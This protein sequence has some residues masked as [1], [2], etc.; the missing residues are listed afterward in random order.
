MAARLP[1]N[2]TQACFAHLTGK[3]A[4]Q[5]GDGDKGVVSAQ[6]GE[7][8]GGCRGQGAVTPATENM[9]STICFPLLRHK[10]P[11]TWSLKTPL[12]SHRFLGPKFVHGSTRFSAQGLTKWKARCQPRLG[13]YQRLGDLSQDHLSVGRIHFPAAVEPSLLASSRSTEE[14]PLCQISDHQ[15]FRLP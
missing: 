14:S 4:G 11:Q 5:Q 8:C 13:S 9:S 7:G 3:V 6:P 12:S 15:T 2:R 10:L 1:E